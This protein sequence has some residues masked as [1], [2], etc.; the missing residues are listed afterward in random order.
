M[1]VL[2]FKIMAVVCQSAC[3]LQVSQPLKWS[4]LSSMPAVNLVKVVISLP[5]AFMGWGHPWS[6]PFQLG[7]RLRWTVM[8]IPIRCALKMGACRLLNS[9]RPRILIS[10]NMGLP[11]ILCLTARFLAMQPLIARLSQNACVSLPSCLRT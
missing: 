10:L 9:L 1:V 4:L 2:R 8:A 6:T 11:C 5:A 7:Y 3:M